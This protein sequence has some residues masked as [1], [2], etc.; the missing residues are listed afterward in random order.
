MDFSYHVADEAE[1]RVT[2]ERVVRSHMPQYK[3]HIRV[4]E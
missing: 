2:I 3:Y 1:A 4:S